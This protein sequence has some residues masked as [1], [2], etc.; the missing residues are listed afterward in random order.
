MSELSATVV[1]PASPG[2]TEVTRVWHRLPRGAPPVVVALVLLVTV[3]C[4][5]R[6][7]RAESPGDAGRTPAT[8]AT[9]PAADGPTEGTLPG[10]PSVRRARRLLAS[11]VEAV[12]RSLDGYRRAAFPHWS[13]QG[14]GCDTREVV[15]ARDGD[16]VRRDAECRAVAGTWHSPYDGRTLHDDAEVDI[17]HVVPLAE[18][19][20]SGAVDWSEARREAFANDLRRPQLVAVSSDV[21]HAK[22]DSPPHEWLPPAEGYRCVYGRAWVAVKAH[23]HLTVTRAERRALAAVLAAC[24]G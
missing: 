21:N 13:P 16:G 22:R 23:Y 14:D 11:L 24:P 20:R 5:Q 3:G 18:A 1:P 12:P 6:V 15:L 2:R 7:D 17:D 10:L 4:A 9:T 19:W 8:P